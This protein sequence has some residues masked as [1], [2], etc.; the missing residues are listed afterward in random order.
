M[1]MSVGASPKHHRKTEEYDDD[2]ANHFE[3]G[4]C[5]LE[6]CKPLVREEHKDRQEHQEDCD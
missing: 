6:P 5:V 1:P 2:Q 4:G 3:D